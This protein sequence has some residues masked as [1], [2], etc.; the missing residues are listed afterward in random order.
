[1]IMSKQLCMIAILHNIRSAHNVGSIFRTADGAGVEK[2][3]LCGFTPAPINEVG[4]PR[5]QLTKVS[6]GAEKNIPWEKVKSTTA[7]VDRLKKRGYRIIAVEQ[8]KN[9]VSLFNIWSHSNKKIVILV[10]NEIKGPSPGILKRAD[11]ILEI[12]MVGRKK[13][14]NVSVAFGIVAYHL[15]FG[16]AKS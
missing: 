4:G 14:L 12:P 11:K 7:L 15:R 8:T 2:I 5:I 1:M 16:S 6:L 13:S 3:Y 9:S 10:G